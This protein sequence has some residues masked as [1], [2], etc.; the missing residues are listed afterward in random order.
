MNVLTETHPLLHPLAY[1]NSKI[2]V[3][4]TSSIYLLNLLKDS[5]LIGGYL[6]TSRYMK[7]I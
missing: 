3:F 6:I 2:L 4:K 1:I 5:I 7:T